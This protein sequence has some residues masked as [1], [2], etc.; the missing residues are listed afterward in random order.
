MVAK[1]NVSLQSVYEKYSAPDG[2]GDKGTAHTYIDIYEKEMTK[3]SGIS[4]L[5]IGVWEGHSLAMWEEYFKDSTIWGID[6]K[7]DRLKYTVP[8]KI[9]DATDATAIEANFSGMDFNYIIDDGSHLVQHQVISRQLLW[10]HLKVGGK[11][12]IEDIVSDAALRQIEQSLSL[13]GLT[14]KVY[15]HRY[16]KNRSDDIMVVIHKVE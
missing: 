10:N 14:Y 7:L 5:E 9:C 12:F 4:L 13:D 11:Y 1:A 3:T 8:A 2:G 15:D 16:M 6:I